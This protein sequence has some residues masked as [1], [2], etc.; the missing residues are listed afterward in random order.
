MVT[1]HQSELKNYAYNTQRVEN[2]CV[3]FDPISLK[4]TYKLTTGMP[5]Q[6]NAF[7]IAIRLGM[8]QSLVQQARELVP[9]REKKWAI[10]P[11]VKRGH[12]ALLQEVML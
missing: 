7:E 12:Y 8:D 11:A 6:S 1:T 3:E 2:A 5:G 9:Q 10:Y 4:P